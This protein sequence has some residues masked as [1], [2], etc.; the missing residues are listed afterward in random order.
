M[1]PCRLLG[2]QV[3]TNNLDK[4][5]GDSSLSS[6]RMLEKLSKEN[7]SNCREQTGISAVSSVR[8]QS[9]TPSLE[10]SDACC[11]GVSSGWPLIVSLYCFSP[12]SGFLQNPASGCRS[13]PLFSE[14]PLVCNT[15]AFVLPQSRLRAHLRGSALHAGLPSFLGVFRSGRSL[16]IQSH[17]AHHCL[18]S[19]LSGVL[20][21]LSEGCKF[22]GSVWQVCSGH[23][24]YRSMQRVV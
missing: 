13:Y 1:L 12:S 21:V 15:S 7:T 3:V 11:C 16:G 10:T 24:A 6:G 17:G 23:V 8:E 19:E 9:T 4:Q 5:G 18:V 2:H 20:P 22:A 14:T